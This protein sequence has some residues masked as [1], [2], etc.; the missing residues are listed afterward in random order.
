MESLYAIILINFV[1][2]IG[3][4]IAG[5]Q[6]LDI[7]ALAPYEAWTHPWQFLT[8][9]FT[10]ASFM[11]ILFNMWALYFFGSSILQILGAKRF[12]LVYLAGGLAGGLAFVGLAYL[13]D[14][15]GMNW[16]GRSYSAA[17]GA[18]GAIFALGGALAV[19]RPNLRVVFFPIPAP[20]PLWIAIIGSFTIF[21]L[22]SIFT[23]MGVAWQAH[24]GGLAFG[25]LAGW[26]YKRRSFN[27]Y[28]WN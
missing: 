12:W 9:M 27:R 6:A 13:G 20:M 22:L 25:A 23:G 21:T 4:K 10:H 26:F 2:F 18:S 15:T 8:S 3:V 5:G 28:R 1:I 16:L 11:H 17:I 7:L 19:L 14:A 24:L